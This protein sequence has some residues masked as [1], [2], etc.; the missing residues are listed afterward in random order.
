MEVWGGGD[1]G[2]RDQDGGDRVWGDRVDRGR[3]LKGGGD[4]GVRDKDGGDC[5]GGD[6]FEKG[7]RSITT[8]KPPPSIIIA[9]LHVWERSDELTKEILMNYKR[10][11]PVPRVWWGQ[12]A[13]SSLC[14]EK[15]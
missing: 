10:G 15:G 2:V 3:G 8:R 12:L 1:R 6:L 11:V 13:L 4:Q 7:C 9:H 5:S 14:A